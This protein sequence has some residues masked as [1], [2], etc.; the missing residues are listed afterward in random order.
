MNAIKKSPPQ[1]SDVRDS[2]IFKG[3]HVFHSPAETLKF[4]KRFAAVLKPGSILALS[5][6]LGSGKTTFMKGLCSGL[7][8][9]GADEVKSPTFVLMH[10][11]EGRCPIYHFDLYRLDSAGE[12]EGLGLEECLAD[13]SSITCVEWA[14]RAAG[15]FPKETHWLKFSTA[16]P[17]TRILVF[18]SAEEPVHDPK[19]R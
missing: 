1:N 4:A 9:R 10:I 2:A 18:D 11:Y 3:K 5:G 19:K 14:E 13:Q 12:A 17:E 16:G 8:V 15:L 6:G 7:G